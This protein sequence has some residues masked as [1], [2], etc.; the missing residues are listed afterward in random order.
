MSGRHRLVWTCGVVVVLAAGLPGPAAAQ[1][2]ERLEITTAGGVRA[3]AIEI[4]KTDA[5]REYGL[6]NRR[7]LPNDRGMLFEFDK[8][9]PVTFWM[10][11][12]LIPLD[13]IFISHD[14]RIVAI[15]EQAQP[16]SEALV[17]SGKPCDAVLELNG[18]A[19]ASLGIKV[20]DVVAYAFFQP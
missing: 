12:T 7:Y 16:L 5:A 9:E 3:I 8:E 15:A 4:A 13:M 17:P 2:L 10:K 6:M 1:N 14:G 20:G 19:A 11:D 18:G